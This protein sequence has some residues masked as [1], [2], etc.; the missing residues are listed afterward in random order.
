MLKQQVLFMRLYGTGGLSIMRS[1][2]GDI[3]VHVTI[4]TRWY[5]GIIKSCKEI[6][7]ST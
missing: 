5:L 7:L 4:Q 3:Q 2:L 6:T 1:H